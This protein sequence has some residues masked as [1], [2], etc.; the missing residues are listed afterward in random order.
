MNRFSTLIPASS[1]VISCQA[2]APNPL[3]DSGVMALMARAA[4]LGGAAGIR[5]NGV[6]DVA[7][8]AAVVSVP[9]IGIDKVGTD[10]V[11]ITPDAETALRLFAAGAR[12]V[13]MDGTLRHRPNGRSLAEEVRRIRD[14]SDGAVMA[15]VDSLA[16]GIRAA[17]SGVD[18][19]ATTLSGYT[20]ENVPL[21][22]DIELIAVLASRIDLPVIAEGR[23]R[24]RADVAAARDAGAHAVV[25]GTAVTNPLAQTAHLLGA[26]P[27]A[28]R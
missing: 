22:P 26:L 14:G 27:A 20:V 9:V 6:A 24:T 7:A 2:Y 8:I 28:A 18:A 25:V 23:I 19:V 13:A 21:E 15:D 17:E 16:A 12:I 11:F 4:E 10:G 1:L 5:A 3:R